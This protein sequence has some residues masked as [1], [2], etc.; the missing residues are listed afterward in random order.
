MGEVIDARARFNAKRHHANLARTSPG[1]AARL[2]QYL[3]LR[4]EQ[5]LKIWKPKNGRT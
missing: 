3:I 4:G 2:H 5:M 1:Y